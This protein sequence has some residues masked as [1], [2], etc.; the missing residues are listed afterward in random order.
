MKPTPPVNRVLDYGCCSPKYSPSNSSEISL[1]YTKLIE[2]NQKLCKENHEL[3]VELLRQDDEIFQLKRRYEEKNNEMSEFIKRIS[4]GLNKPISMIK[5]ELNNS[6]SGIN[7]TDMTNLLLQSQKEIECLKKKNIYMNQELFE[8]KMKS[9]VLND[10]LNQ[11]LLKN[12]ELSNEI[13]NKNKIIEENEYKR[14]KYNELLKEFKDY[15]NDSSTRISGLQN[16]INGLIEENE[17]LYNNLDSHNKEIM[18]KELEYK[19]NELR[20]AIE[21]NNELEEKY[22]KIFNENENNKLIISQ[23]KCNDN[24][25]CKNIKYCQLNGIDIILDNNNNDNFNNNNNV[26]INDLME[27]INELNE[28]VNIYKNEIIEMKHV[29]LLLFQMK[30]INDENQKKESKY[31]EIKRRNRSLEIINKNLEEDNKNNEEKIEQLNRE[32]KEYK[33]KSKLEP[34]LST[35]IEEF[36]ITSNQLKQSQSDIETLNRII[37][38]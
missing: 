4:I 31:E 16:K 12:E 6:N 25:K 33:D 2:N 7:V 20:K 11:I 23:F 1:R 8:I 18:K 14:V 27:R 36:N 10:K 29:L 5:N 38:M 19:E 17:S 30:Q 21:E 34:N 26:M 13:E 15:Q 3:K 24:N 37:R 32:I 22:N 35:I 28:E 9:P